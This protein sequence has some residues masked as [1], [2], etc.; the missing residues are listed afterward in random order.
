MYP[1][2]RELDE[3][4]WDLWELRRWCRDNPE[5]KGWISGLTF[6]CDASTTDEDGYRPLTTQEIAEV[7]RAISKGA[8]IGQVRKYAGDNFM[9]YVR[10]MRYGKAS[11]QL[12]VAREVVCVS[13][14]VGTKTVE[15]PDPDAPKVT[16]EVEV[17]EWDCLP[18]LKQAEEASA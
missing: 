11:V 4:Q 16:K 6:F 1:A 15:V 2:H 8:P 17:L 12:M 9:T 5:V 10:K 13:R 7:V 18:L 3:M 14:V